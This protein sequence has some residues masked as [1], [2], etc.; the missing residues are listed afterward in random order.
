[1]STYS[2]V[3]KKTDKNKDFFKAIKC[4]ELTMV[5]LGNDFFKVTIFEENDAELEK[6]IDSNFQVID[7]MLEV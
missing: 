1:M 2:F 6:V 4:T 3:F 7:A 5:D